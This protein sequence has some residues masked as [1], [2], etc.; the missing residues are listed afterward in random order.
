MQIDILQDIESNHETLLIHFDKNVTL[1]E[2]S[3]N[4]SN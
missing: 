4:L 1:T 2:S 3:I